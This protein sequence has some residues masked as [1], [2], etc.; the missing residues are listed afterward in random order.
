MYYGGDTM[1]PLL[2]ERK[3]ELNKRDKVSAVIY[4]PV[5]RN[6]FIIDLLSWFLWAFAS[7]TNPI[8][9]PTPFE[10]TH[11]LPEENSVRISKSYN[12]L[13]FKYFKVYV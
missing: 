9:H 11:H 13:T 2:E 3:L 6:C 5:S 10:K 1:P 7:R 8:S 4:H 12:R